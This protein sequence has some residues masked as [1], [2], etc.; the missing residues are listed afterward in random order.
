MIS[1][2]IENNSTIEKP[3]QND[4]KNDRNSTL[5]SPTIYIHIYIEAIQP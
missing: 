3:K 2:T 5:E 1:S 4:R